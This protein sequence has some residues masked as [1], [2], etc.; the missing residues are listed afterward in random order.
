MID[1][2]EFEHGFIKG[3]CQEG[4][5]VNCG[6]LGKWKILRDY[7]DGFVVDE[8]LKLSYGGI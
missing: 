8:S 5:V 3:L 1:C 4:V 7:V 6:M 2:G